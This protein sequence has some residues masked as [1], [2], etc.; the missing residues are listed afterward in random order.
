MAKARASRATGAAIVVDASRNLGP[1]AVDRFALGQGGLSAHPMI[2]AHTDEVRWL[3]PRVIRLFVQ[4]FF[5][6]YPES[7]RFDW[8]RLDKAVDAILATGAKP[9]MSVCIKP[10]PLYP[11]IHDQDKP[12]PSDYAEWE[13][14]IEAMVRHYNVERKDGIA[15]WEVFNE[16]DIGEMGGCPCRFTPEQYARYYEHTARAVRRADG[17][18]KVGGPALAW[19]ESP[20]LPALLDACD[21]KRLALDFVSW[22]YYTDDPDNITRSIEY[23]KGLLAGHPRL[24]PE[25]IIDEWNI[26]L[27]WERLDPAFQPAFVLETT[28]RMLDGG[29]DLSCYYHI[30]DWHV[31][32]DEFAPFMSEKGA[33]FM[34]WWWNINPQFHALWDFQGAMRPAYFAFRMLA[35]LTGNRI[36][37]ETPSKTVK[38]LAT[39]DPVYDAYTIVAWN[40]RVKKPRSSRVK[41]RMTGITP[42]SWEIRRRILDAETPSALENDRLP[43]VENKRIEV[44]KDLSLS[45]DLEGYGATIL[46]VRRVG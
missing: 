11:D 15:Y 8:S 28:S 35:L 40:F 9:L 21:K 38:A 29:V 42:G 33:S 12:E 31:S 30:R 18:A 22:H 46:L 14:L 27:G 41:L 4:E 32:R 36:A 45:F 16:P 6:V 19:Y 2:T 13:R 24:K 23:V 34:T 17:N 7:G 20:L 10:A 25:L 43:L 26:S 39:Y 1:L 3:R 37:V 5:G 44:K